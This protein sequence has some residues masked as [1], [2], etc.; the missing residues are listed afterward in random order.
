MGIF[1]RIS[2]I[3]NANI[4]ALLDRAENPEKMIRNIIQ[5]MEDTLV[6]VRS[7]AAKGI[8]EQKQLQRELKL[9]ETKQADW[10]SKAELALNKQRE[11]LAKAAL[12][13]K[14]KLVERVNALHDHAQFIAADLEK[15]HEDI[16][17]LQEKI[18]DARAKQQQL[19]R[20]QLTAQTQLKVRDKTQVKQTKVLDKMHQFERKIDHLESQVEAY[21][22]GSKN[23]ED[24]FKS[25]AVEEKINQELNQLKKQL[26]NTKGD[27]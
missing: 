8:A 17:H 9:L 3:I 5:E 22:L 21:H 20:R 25:L 7:N 1:S 13:E 6:E 2:D 12:L 19:L 18:K 14:N 27:A 26:D 4:N 10:Q 23:L 15:Y 11:D 16:A 24:E